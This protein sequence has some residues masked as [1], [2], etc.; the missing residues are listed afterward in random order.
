ML[1]LDKP[2]LSPSTIANNKRYTIQITS[3]RILK[4]AQIFTKSMIEKGYDAYIQ[5]SKINNNN[6]WY[7]VRIGSYDNY[8]LA[9][10][11]A[12]DISSALNMP[13]WIDFI[14]KEE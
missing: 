12:R 6:I 1:N 10:L 11:A 13:T 9:S 8:N 7:R 4:D 3:K 14:R 5:K 2:K